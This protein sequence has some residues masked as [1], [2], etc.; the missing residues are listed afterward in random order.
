MATQDVTFA[1]VQVSFEVEPG[2]TVA[3]FALRAT[4]GE[5]GTFGEYQ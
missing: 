1:D 2:V 4:D 3:G 5:S